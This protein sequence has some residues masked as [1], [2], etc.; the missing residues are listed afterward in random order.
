MTQGGIHIGIGGWV[1]EPW[2]GTFYPEGL[3]QKDELAYVGAHLTGTEINATYYRLQNPKTFAGWARAV[4]D[5][6]KFAVKGSRYVTNRRVLAEAG[7]S[8]S[9]FMAQGL[10]ELG[11]RLGPILWQFAPTKQ[12][13]A[14]DF[15]AFLNLLPRATDGVNFAHALE[16]RHESFACDAFLELAEK[17]RLLSE[18]NIEVERKNRE[19][20]QAKLAL[21]EKATQLALSSKYKSEFLANMSH[22][23]RTPL[24]SLRSEE[25]TSEL[26][27][28]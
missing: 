3:R 15:G 25:H 2:R 4:P 16:V 5:G 7:E 8:I 24:N 23:L 9:K 19:V 20:E 1:Y 17:A 18:Q 14:E 13:D 6:F 26:Q 10:T 21:E 22:E 12:F 11:D 27:S 28:H